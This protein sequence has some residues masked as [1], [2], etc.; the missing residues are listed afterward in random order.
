VEDDGDDD[1]F[2]DRSMERR[3]LDC[4]RRKLEELEGKEGQIDSQRTEVDPFE[5]RQEGRKAGGTAMM[6]CNRQSKAS[7]YPVNQT[8]IHIEFCLIFHLFTSGSKQDGQ[9]AATPG[10]V[11]E[12]G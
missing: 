10:T 5:K 7:K 8:V 11:T 12:G 6:T 9:Q 2:R 4:V 3:T 1:C